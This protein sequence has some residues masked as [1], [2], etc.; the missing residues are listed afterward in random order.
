MR[1]G[2]GRVEPQR[3]A[4]ARLRLRVAA[5]VMEDVAK[6]EVRLEDVR[7]ERDRALVER[8]SLL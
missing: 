1:V 5:E 7:L 8:L 3:V 4:V 2:V 6:V